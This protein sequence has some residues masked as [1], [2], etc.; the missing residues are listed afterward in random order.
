MEE[1]HVKKDQFIYFYIKGNIAQ[2]EIDVMN[3]A[4]EGM[5][6]EYST[7][8]ARVSEAHLMRNI[9]L[10]IGKNIFGKY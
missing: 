10:G 4:I 1:G 3:S 2:K 6:V 7:Y 8:S 5:I 9:T